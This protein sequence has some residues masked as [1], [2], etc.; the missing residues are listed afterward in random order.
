MPSRVESPTKEHLSTGTQN[1]CTKTSD[2]KPRKNNY[3]KQ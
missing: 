2:A 3:F 1:L